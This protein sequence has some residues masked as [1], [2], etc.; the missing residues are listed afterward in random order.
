MSKCRTH[1]PEKKVNPPKKSSS[2]LKTN[3][4][5][6]SAPLIAPVQVELRSAE[7]TLLPQDEEECR[8]IYEKLLSLQPNGA[9]ADMNTL[10]RALYPP[11][12][13]TAFSSSS[14]TP[15]FKSSRPR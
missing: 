15:T 3:Q 8:Q 12:G 11:V 4:R 9:C 14:L 5:S 13:T 6:E 10:R 1:R 7:V 2:V